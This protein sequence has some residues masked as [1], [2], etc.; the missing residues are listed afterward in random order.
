MIRLNDFVD[1]VYVITELNS[2]RN[3]YIKE[4]LA[5]HNIEYSFIV[6]TYANAYSPTPNLNIYE[7]SLL[8]ANLSIFENAIINGYDK[9]AVL[10]NDVHLVDDFEEKFSLFIEHVPPD[11]FIYN[12]ED[13]YD[14]YT[15]KYQLINDYCKR[16]ISI[17]YGSVFLIYNSKEILNVLKKSIISMGKNNCLL[18][19][20]NIASMIY[21]SLPCYCPNDILAYGLS[22]ITHPLIKTPIKHSCADFVFPTVIQYLD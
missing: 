7:Q 20:D 6:S 2:V 12:I 19:I 8:Y 13:P 11:V 5:K 16:I 10:E 21:T 1:K 14:N 15:P 17:R 3:D 18:P 9:I 4:H 22:E